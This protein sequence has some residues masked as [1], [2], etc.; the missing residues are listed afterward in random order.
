MGYVLKSRCRIFSNKSE[1]QKYID[2]LRQKEVAAAVAKRQKEEADAP[3]GLVKSEWRKDGFGTVAVITSITIKNC[4]DSPW[5][6]I[7][8]VMS[9]YA[10]SG[11]KLGAVPF[12]IYDIVPPK[13]IKT[14]ENIRVGLL[15]PPAD[16]ISAARIVLSSP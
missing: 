10:K 6:D 12:V 7:H 9:F 8:G 16:Q 5:V 3:C 1:A 13:K 15:P 4:S 2:S 14:F 11:T